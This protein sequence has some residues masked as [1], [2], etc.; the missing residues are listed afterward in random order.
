MEI[1]NQ[2]NLSKDKKEIYDKMINSEYRSSVI[3]DLNYNI[4]DNGSYP[5]IPSTRLYIPLDFWFC[6]NMGMALPLIAM[7]YTFSRLSFKFSKLNDLYKMGNPLISPSELLSNNNLSPDNQIIYNY[8]TALE[9]NTGF[10]KN[11]LIT[12][13]TPYEWNQYYSIL[14]NYIFLGDDE[15]KYFAQSSHE[16][17]I[18]QN[19]YFT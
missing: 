10:S 8:L 3:Q 12:L 16:Y 4:S 15:R 11:N 9:E 6:K 7:Q 13:F 5:S 18:D 14:A 1:Y 17:L 19:Q 2:L